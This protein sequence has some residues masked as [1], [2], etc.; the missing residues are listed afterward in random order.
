VKHRHHPRPNVDRPPAVG[1]PCSLPRGLRAIANEALAAHRR[2]GLVVLD[3]GGSAPVW[4]AADRDWFAANPTRSHRLRR[5]FA[6]ELITVD[7]DGMT[8][9]LV[10]QLE[11]GSRV[12]AFLT[13]GNDGAVLDTCFGIQ[14][15]SDLEAL[16]TALWSHIEAGREV[17]LN[18]VI[19][20]AI[21]TVSL[22]QGVGLQ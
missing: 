22:T 7:C 4:K 11:P 5:V 14:K 21:S 15:A 19:A 1:A 12:R 16:I 10:K 18:D 8:H 17:N 3:V 20:E 9:A 13:S 2:G 6:G